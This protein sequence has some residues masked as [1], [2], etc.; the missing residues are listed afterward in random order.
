MRDG[1]NPMMRPSVASTAVLLVPT[2]SSPIG[3]ALPMIGP[4]PSIAKMPSTID[5][6]LGSEALMSKIDCG[7]PA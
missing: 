1:S 2:T 3:L 7:M 5:T 6:V 4:S